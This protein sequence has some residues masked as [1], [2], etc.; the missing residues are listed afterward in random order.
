MGKMR[1]LTSGIALGAALGMALGLSVAAGGAS[2]QTGIKFT[3]DWKFQ[4]PT[5]AFLMAADKGYFAQEGLDVSID[6]GNGSAGA[7]TRVASGAYQMGFADINSLVEFNLANPD[8]AARAVMMAYDAPP[9]SVW[10]MKSS[11]IETPAD[12]VG[13]RLGAPVFDASYRLFPAFAA[14]TGIDDSK[15]V[16]VNMDPPL[17]ETMLVR[18]EV[19]FISGHHFSSLLDLKSKGV[20]EDELVHFLYSD[21]GMDFYGNAVIASD[22]FA[23]E[24]PEAVRGFLRALTRGWKDVAADPEASIGAVTAMDPLVD[25]A[26]EL[27]RLKLALDV[28]VLTPYVLEHGIGDVDPA[29]LQRSIDQLAVALG[30]EETPAPEDI[31]TSEFLPPAQERMISR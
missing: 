19:D 11:G 9:F 29:R 15:V 24:N 31:W 5:A 25:P 20:A 28:N 16:R 17:R 4:G 7:I 27:E 22:A 13:K 14:E 10:A 23:E 18:G 26:L 8:Q 21:Y 30:L 3:L 12:L 2:A 6:S 1:K